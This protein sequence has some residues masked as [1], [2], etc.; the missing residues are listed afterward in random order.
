MSFGTRNT[1]RECERFTLAFSLYKENCNDEE[2]N[3]LVI[4]L[5]KTSQLLE[6]A[7]GGAADGKK[8]G[9]IHL[10]TLNERKVLKLL[11]PLSHNPPPGLKTEYVDITMWVHQ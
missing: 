8:D 1:K 5:T 7:Y 6:R 11:F 2:G 9:S 10:M 3:R 4:V